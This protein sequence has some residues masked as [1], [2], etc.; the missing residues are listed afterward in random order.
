MTNKLQT[1]MASQDYVLL[2]GS[3][4]T[5]LFGLGLESGDPPEAWNVLHPNRVR[6]VHQGYVD[7]GSNLILTN[8][9]GGTRFRLKL[10]KL[11]DR[12]HELNKAAAENARAVADAADHSVVVAGSMGPTGELFEPMGE[13]TFEAAKAAFAEQARG[14]V[15]GGVDV[16]WVETMSDLQE[17]EA[18]VAGIR[19]VTDLPMVATMTFDSNG[20]TMMGVSPVRAIETLR[21]FELVAL[22]GNC[23]N[24][25]DEIEGV[26]H[27][28][29]QLDPSVPLVAKAN[30]GIPTLG[31]GGELRYNGTPE[32][33]AEYALKVKGLGATLIG[34]C[35]GSTP[36]HIRE[37]KRALDTR[38]AIV[39][40]M[41]PDEGETAPDSTGRRS[42]R[43][44][45]K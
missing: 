11:D 3:M 35:C 5:M 7:A 38:A 41:S 40:D 24:G 25:P 39:P 1:L 34:A 21:A 14:L 32:V 20:H 15:D 30:A 16:L 33:M 31:P 9:F 8:S 22:G 13:L 26:I 23:G 19:A 27:K 10:H 42:R 44:G 43:R 36:D 28:M 45:R 29:H 37:M 17:V 12:V 6:T 4:G 2:D 18:A